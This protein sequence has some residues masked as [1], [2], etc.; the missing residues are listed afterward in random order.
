MIKCLQALMLDQTS[1][2]QKSFQCDIRY[3]LG[4]REFVAVK[5][6]TI[7][8]DVHYI[9]QTLIQKIP[10]VLKRCVVGL[11]IMIKRVI[12]MSS[13][14][15]GVINSSSFIIKNILLLIYI[16]ISALNGKNTEIHANYKK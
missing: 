7:L 9:F 8:K 12:M 2:R 14:L 16:S 6:H 13:V 11:S 3:L 15:Y 4:D 10:L 1:L 5:M